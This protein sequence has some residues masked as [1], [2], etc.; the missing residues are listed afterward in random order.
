MIKDNSNKKSR[1]WLARGSITVLILLQLLL[2][3]TVIG[4]VL[5]ISQELRK[6]ALENTRSHLRIQ[7]QNLEDRLTQ[8]F[9]LLRMHLNSL[10]IE[11]PQAHDNPLYLKEA[12]MSLQQKLPYIRSLSLMDNQGEI[13]LSTQLENIGLTPELGTLLPQVDAGI[14][15]LLRFGRPWFGRD[16]HQAVPEGEQTEG[17]NTDLSFFPVT[18]VS[19]ELPEW[20]F[21]LAISSDY[22]LNLAFAQEAQ[23]GLSHRMF[24]DDGVMLFSSVPEEHPGMLLPENTGLEDLLFRHSG[25]SYWLSADGKPQLMAFR[26]SSK[27]PW[28]VQSLACCEAVLKD[29]S[30]GNQRLWIF[31]SL[32][33]AA[34]LI[35]TTFLT[36][37]VRKSLGREEQFFE[38]HRQAAIVFSHSSDLIAILDKEGRVLAVNPAF[39]EH[40]GYQETK[41]IGHSLRPLLPNYDELRAQ[42]RDK[43]VWEGELT[44]LRHDGSYIIGW[45]VV[46]TIRDQEQEISHFVAVFR[47][48]SHIIESEA[49]IRRLSQAVEQSPSSVVITSLDA[50]IEYANPEFFRATG[51]SRKEVLG[52]NPNILQSGLTSEQTYRALWDRI[53]AGQVWEGEFINR[54]KDGSV[55][56]ERSIVSPLFDEKK[57]ITGYLAIK[58]DVTSEKV[59]ERELRLA[60][61]VIQSTLEAVMIC[62][63]HKKIIDVNPAFI[64]I[65]GYERAEVL[66]RSA[67]MLGSARRNRQ[68][69]QQMFAALNDVGYWQGEFWNRHKSG[70]E[71]AI[72]ASVSRLVD[73]QG[74]VTNYI[75]MFSDVTEQKNLQ[76]SLEQ[77]AHFDL[78]TG[79]PN[80]ALFYERLKQAKISA[81]SDGLSFGIGFM[82]LDHFKTVNDTHGHDAGD[83]LLVIIA[84]RL[85]ATV[86]NSD[87]VARLGGDEFVL[88]FNALGSIDEA[89]GIAERILE[90]VREPVTVAGHQ[91]QVSG[92][93]GITIYPLDNSDIEAL[94]QHADAAMYQAKKLGRDRLVLAAE[95]TTP[96]E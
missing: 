29:W 80:R 81:D 43:G 70:A 55:F 16:F 44:V 54:R 57:E 2:V 69:R 24:T 13:V 30:Q 19:S 49:T 5:Y 95:L 31:T 94:M 40:T 8:S 87:F 96:R 3:V 88:I 83:D 71:Y 53:T 90:C 68:I 32:V 28:F 89:V 6:E 65:T 46:N 7:T 33:L 34:V 86:R 22:F 59:A 25:T 11:H 10:T 92:S 50:Q 52:K 1:G 37:R 21:L 27:Y 91:V 20:T 76:K 42:V 56:Y 72:L 15:N 45:L 58:H 82:D 47:D 64:K 75:S 35:V 48:L 84:N 77:R 26:I 23:E 12:L 17:Q 74:Q 4:S 18:M 79:L 51:Y 14:P 61:S 93:M 73:D 38:E 41:F 9:D 85:L 60:A 62:D 39:E 78:L 36:Y 63:E 66:G 67:S